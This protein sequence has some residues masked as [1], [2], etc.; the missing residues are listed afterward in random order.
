MSRW[1]RGNYGAIGTQLQV[2]A[3]LLCETV[4]LRAGA[5][6]LDVATGTGNAA[7]AAARRN[8]VVTG[9]DNAPEL[10][11]HARR[12]A[13]TEGLAV[14][15]TEADAG[16]LPFADGSF[17]YVISTLGVQFAPDHER[18]AAELRRV[19]RGTIAMSNWTPGG[20]SSAYSDIVA[21][22]MPPSTAPSPYVW[23]EADGLRELLGSD[24]H[25][26]SRVFR[27]RF[28]RPEDWLDCFRTHFGPMIALYE[29]LEP[30]RQD[31]LTS[32]INAT[33]ARFNE[34]DDGTLVLP[35]AYVDAVWP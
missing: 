16:K 15:F 14:E 3:E 13:A 22:Y 2:I 26:R 27:Y 11:H 12:R 6:V 31:D 7:L 9:V 21:R 24:A 10:L 35:I 29:S 20:F 25:L 4:G 1:G 8:C 17:D 34:A 19:C 30:A 28:P 33:V 5:T 32:E 23:G 18:A